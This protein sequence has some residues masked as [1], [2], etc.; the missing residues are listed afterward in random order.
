MSCLFS[1][2][3]CRIYATSV[4]TGDI[5]AIICLRYEGQN[6]L[7]LRGQNCTLLSSFVGSHFRIEFFAKQ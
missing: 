7:L 1:A 5:N 6:L 2:G 4:N 3:I